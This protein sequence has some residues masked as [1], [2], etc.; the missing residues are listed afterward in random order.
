MAVLV[1]I[2]KIVAEHQLIRLFV[3][4]VSNVEIGRFLAHNTIKNHMFHDVAKLLAYITTVVL[5]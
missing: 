5:Y 3:A 4:N 1:P 2:N